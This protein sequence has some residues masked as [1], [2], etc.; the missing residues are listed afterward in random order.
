[1]RFLKT[2]VFHHWVPIGSAIHFD[3]SPPPPFPVPSGLRC[4]QPPASPL[5]FPQ[6]LAAIFCELS[7]LQHS[8]DVVVV[9]LLDQL[10]EE[11]DVGSCRG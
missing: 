6:V 2:G 3:V 7:S 5:S 8:S 10:F 1:M 9:F 4:L 11:K